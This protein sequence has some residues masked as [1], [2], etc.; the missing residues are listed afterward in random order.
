MDVLVNA[1]TLVKG[2]GVQV[3]ASFV[4]ESLKDAEKQDADNSDI[5]WHYALSPQVAREVGHEVP[6][7]VL[8][9]TSPSRD[10]NTRA[11]VIQLQKDLGVD[12]VFTVFGPAYTQFT[13]GI[14]IIVKLL[15]NLDTRFS[16]SNL[17]LVR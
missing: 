2:G 3:G 12:A 17:C 11:G 8:F 15:I 7:S 13:G 10:K 9:E 16:C 5:T 14:Y 6:R 1:T 4:A